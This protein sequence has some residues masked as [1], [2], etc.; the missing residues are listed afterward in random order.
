MTYGGFCRGFYNGY[1]VD[2][3]SEQLYMICFDK[4]LVF[5]EAWFDFAAI[6]VH[7]TKLVFVVLTSSKVWVCRQRVLFKVFFVFSTFKVCTVNRIVS[8]LVYVKSQYL[9]EHTTLLDVAY[10][11]LNV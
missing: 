6:L 3:N 1:T 9:S 4:P 7:K 8:L 11:I 10:I 2:L 5:Y